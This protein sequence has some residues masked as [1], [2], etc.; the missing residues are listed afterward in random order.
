MKTT[1]F[2]LHQLFLDQGMESERSLKL[3]RHP[4]LHFNSRL[5]DHID[6]DQVIASGDLELFQAVQRGR[7]LGNDLVAFFAGEAGRISRFLG[8][9]E[10]QAM[11]RWD[12][13]ST[14]SELARQKKFLQDGEV[15]HVLERIPKFDPLINR[16]VIS[17]PDSGRHHQ[18][19]SRNGKVWKSIPVHEIRSVGAARPFPGFNQV[20]LQFHELKQI[21]HSDAGGWREALMST[22][23]VY[24]ISDKKSGAQYVGSATGSRG[25]WGRWE[26][27][28]NNV[29]GGN[30]V[31]IQSLDNLQLDATDLQFS[32][33]E[34]LGSLSNKEE[35]LAA[36]KLW[37]T[38]LGKKAIT[39]NGN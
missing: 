16:L 18:W 39:L 7:L 13:Q 37:K 19:L 5:A 11:E 14:Q 1:L 4:K 32:I 26:S 20:I 21:I 23:G 25:L 15:W 35:G 24:L 29:H 36:E 3:Y 28:A 38:K 2:D 30:K 12:F 22:R 10:V 27:Y 8:M 6:I 33:L 9:W 31:M 17:W 34:T